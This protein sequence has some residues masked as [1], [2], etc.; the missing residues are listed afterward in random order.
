VTL[1]CKEKNIPIF[2]VEKREQLGEWA[3]LCKYD[4]EA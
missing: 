2:N 3:G 4:A 1:L